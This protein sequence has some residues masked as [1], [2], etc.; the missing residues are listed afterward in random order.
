MKFESK[1]SKW[2]SRK[3]LSKNINKLI[4]RGD[5]ENLNLFLHNSVSYKMIVNLNVFSISMKDR[6]CRYI[7]STEIIT[8]NRRS[9]SRMNMEISQ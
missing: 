3:R 4:V 9:R 5:K 2:S 6:I 7:R 8:P 1:S